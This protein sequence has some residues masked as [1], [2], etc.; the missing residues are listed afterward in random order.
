MSTIAVPIDTSRWRPRGL[1]HQ[2]GGSWVVD[3][4][5][6]AR[7]PEDDPD[8]PKGVGHEFSDHSLALRVRRAVENGVWHTSDPVLLTDVGGNT[9]VSANLR[10]IGKYADTDLAAIG[11]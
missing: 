3:V 4:V 10:T 11:Y 7:D 9:Y 6:T 2:C 1:L 8:R 5:W